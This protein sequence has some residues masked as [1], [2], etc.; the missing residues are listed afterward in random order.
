MKY[1]SFCIK[2]LY[3]LNLNQNEWPVILLCL[4]LIF[5]A[6]ILNF[7]ANLHT[8]LTVLEYA[9]RIMLFLNSTALI[10]ICLLLC[11]LVIHFLRKVLV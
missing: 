1:S 7:H 3:E 4:Y 5:Y 2:T 11:I 8:K 9:Y 10:G 6:Y